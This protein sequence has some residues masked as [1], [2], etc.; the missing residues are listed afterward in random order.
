MLTDPEKYTSDPDYY[1]TGKVIR[2]QMIE[3]VLGIRVNEYTAREFRSRIN[4]S[5]VHAEFPN[6][7][8]NKVNYDS[9]VKALAFFSIK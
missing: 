5:R 6:G 3:I 9:S 2:R 1:A 8:V 7:Y 4:G